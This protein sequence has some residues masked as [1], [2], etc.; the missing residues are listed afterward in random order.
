MADGKTGLAGKLEAGEQ[1]ITMETNLNYFGQMLRQDRRTGKKKG[2]AF[3]LTRCMLGYLGKGEYP[4][5]YVKLKPVEDIN[6]LYSFAERKDLPYLG[7]YGKKTWQKLSQCLKKYGL[8]PLKLPREW[9]E[10]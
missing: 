7:H 2:M 6:G 5:C 1:R 10:S 4:G 9:S 8:P 3:H